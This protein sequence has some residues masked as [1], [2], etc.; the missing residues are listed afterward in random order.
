MNPKLFSYLVVCGL[1]LCAVPAM[2]SSN[3]GATAWVSSNHIQVINIESGEVL[4]RLPL[5]E[6][7]HE[8]QFTGAGDRLYVATS[9]AL[10]VVDPEQM[11]FTAVLSKRRAKAVAVSSDGEHVFAL[12]PGDPKLSQEARVAGTPLP[13][14]TLSHYSTATMTEVRSWQVPAMSFDVAISP[15]GERV[16]VLDPTAGQVQIYSS[17]G[18]L[19]EKVSVT[20][21]DEAGRPQQGMFGWMAVSPDGSSIV[22]PVTMAAGAVL[23]EVDLLPSATAKRV[24]LEPLQANGRIQGLAW[25]GAGNEVLIT[26]VGGVCSYKQGSPQKWTPHAVNYVDIEPVPASVD[27]VAVAPVFSE[28]N[29]S[30]G[31]SVISA[32]GEVLRSIELPDMSPFFVAVR[33]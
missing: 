19:L 27:S 25:N 12:H 21:V 10:R 7:I 6:F 23:A 8:M 31:V 16:F 30:G 11:A 29:K 14:A 22:F 28:R 33:P 24:T 3:S 5:R 26:A 20:P 15:T 2:A 9:Q 18:A 13:L 1:S 4:S 32:K 17:Q